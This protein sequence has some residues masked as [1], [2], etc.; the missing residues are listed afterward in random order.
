MGVMRFGGLTNNCCG[1]FRS[2][3]TGREA[4]LHHLDDPDVIWTI[5]MW[6]NGENQLF[7]LLVAGCN[8][9]FIGFSQDFHHFFG[10][11]V[12]PE[13]R[14]FKVQG[15]PNLLDMPLGLDSFP[16][17]GDPTRTRQ[18]SDCWPSLKQATSSRVAS[19]L[20]EDSQVKRC[21]IFSSTTFGFV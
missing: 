14:G 7:S 11:S 9:V 5:D 21:P 12:F 6:R 20:A 17:A 18:A 19:S 3:S 1:F 10:V 2:F 8:D 4:S 15:P 16:G 13:I